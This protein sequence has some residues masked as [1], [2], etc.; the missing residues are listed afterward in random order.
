MTFDLFNPSYEAKKIY[1]KLPLAKNPSTTE[2]LQIEIGGKTYSISPSKV[3]KTV[4]PSF[5]Y[6]TQGDAENLTNIG[7]ETATYEADVN[8]AD[9]STVYIGGYFNKIGSASSDIILQLNSTDYRIDG[10]KITADNLEE[11]KDDDS[12]TEN[13][14]IIRSDTNAT[15]NLHFSFPS[16]V[17]AKKVFIET[18][19]SHY[20]VK[21]GDPF[22]KINGQ[23]HY[24][25]KSEIETS[26]KVLKS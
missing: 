14:E 2:N 24:L 23:K 22:L 4:D 21:Q 26:S 10:S 20:G 6:S 8:P 17:K 19:V 15:F 9:N 7:Q 13:S 3:E 16:D 12:T 25:P 5:T 11:F 18:A 1:L